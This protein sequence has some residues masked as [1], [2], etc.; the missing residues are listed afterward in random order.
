MSLYSRL[1]PDHSDHVS[2][3]SLRQRPPVQSTLDMLLPSLPDVFLNILQYFALRLDLKQP[4]HLPRI[5]ISVGIACLLLIM[6]MNYAS[7]DL[8]LSL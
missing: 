7:A 5:A 6:C 1:H 8:P 4:V 2:T 3:G